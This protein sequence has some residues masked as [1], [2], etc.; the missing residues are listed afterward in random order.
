MT[1]LDASCLLVGLVGCL[2][3]NCDVGIVVLAALGRAIGE[4]VILSGSG[5]DRC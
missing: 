2:E 5:N 3:G 1:S 4:A